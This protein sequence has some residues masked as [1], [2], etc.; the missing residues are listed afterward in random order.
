MGEGLAQEVEGI[1]T[2]PGCCCFIVM[3]GPDDQGIGG[4]GGRAED[5]QGAIDPSVEIGLASFFEFQEAAGQG[6][7]S[8][9]HGQVVAEVIM[10]VVAIMER[11]GCLV[12]SHARFFLQ[13]LNL[14]IKLSSLLIGGLNISYVN[15]KWYRHLI[16]V[17]KR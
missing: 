4:D 5:L 1:G 6:I 16:R 13:I 3:Q 8:Y 9:C 10:R 14:D 15:A 12:Q 2:V 17:E 7:F 11:Y